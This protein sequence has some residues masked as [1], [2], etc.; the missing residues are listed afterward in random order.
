MILMGNSI[1]HIWVN[2]IHVYAYDNCSIKSLIFSGDG[3][4]SVD[5]RPNKRKASDGLFGRVYHF[6]S[7]TDVDY[8]PC[9]GDYNQDGAIIIS[10]K[11]RA[12]NNDHGYY[13]VPV[14]VPVDLL[15]SRDHRQ[16]AVRHARRSV[17]RA[18]RRIVSNY[19]IIKYSAQ[20]F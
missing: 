1:Q 2:G 19:L 6:V 4:S 20:T 16:L 18:L 15:P 8:R 7:F 9:H 13:A 14:E 12:V 10:S 3:G 5:H 11:R 17:K